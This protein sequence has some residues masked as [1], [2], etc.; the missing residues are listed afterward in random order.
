MCEMVFP[1][2]QFERATNVY[3]QRVIISN[4]SSLYITQDFYARPK[5]Y[6]HRFNI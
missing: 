4:G 1:N 5:I 2:D 6:T 3:C